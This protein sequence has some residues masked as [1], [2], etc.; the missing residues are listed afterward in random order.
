MVEV[1]KL[2]LLIRGDKLPGPDGRGLGV[3]LGQ[4]VKRTPEVFVI[5]AIRML[6]RQL[7]QRLESRVVILLGDDVQSRLLEEN[8]PGFEG[9]RGGR[10]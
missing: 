7:R 6:G 10:V 8:F 5:E 3:F 4:G 9:L 1:A 2:S